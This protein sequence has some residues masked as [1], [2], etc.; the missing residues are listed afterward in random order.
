[1]ND[2]V[3]PIIKGNIHYDEKYVKVNGDDAFD[4]NAI[5]SK[6]KFILAHLFVEKRTKKKCI[7][8]LKQIK[9]TCY[10]QILTKYYIAKYNETKSKN[11]VKFVCDKFANYKS[12]FNKLFY[13]IA[14]LE[15]GVPIACKKYNFEHNNNPIERYNGKTKDRIKSIRSGFKNFEDAKCFIDLRRIIYNYVNPHQ[16]LKGKTP[17]ENAGINLKLERNKLLNLIKYVKD[18]YAPLS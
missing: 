4:L 18:N 11:K 5:D 13:R 1:M 12:A 15:F 10:N 3:S 7:E 6:S 16:E 17:A 9:D 8:F 14:E 2:N